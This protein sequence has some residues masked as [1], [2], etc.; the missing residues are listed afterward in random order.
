MWTHPHLIGIDELSAEDVT[1]VLDCA[2]KALTDRAP[3]VLD[4][5]IDYREYYDLA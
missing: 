1:H 2:E 4:V 5:P 3:F